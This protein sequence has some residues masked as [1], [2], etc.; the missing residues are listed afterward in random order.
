ML[1][2]C[3]H[4]GNEI[5]QV[6]NRVVARPSLV[7]GNIRASLPRA[8]VSTKLFNVELWAI[9]AEVGPGFQTVR[10]MGSMQ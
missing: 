1:Y 7:V 10:A 9:I 2:M 4:Y 6:I 5:Y 8:R 3:I